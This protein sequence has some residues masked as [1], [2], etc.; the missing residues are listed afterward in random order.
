MKNGMINES[1][2][3]DLVNLLQTVKATKEAA[4][5]FVGSTSQLYMHPDG[6]IEVDTGAGAEHAAI[7]SEL[8]PRFETTKHA[9]RQMCA[10]AKI[11]A[12]Y[13]DRCPPELLAI[14]ANHWFK[15]GTDDKGAPARML[16]TMQ[17]SELLGIERPIVR[18]FTS[19]KYRRVDNW[20]FVNAVFPVLQEYHDKGLVIDSVN[21]G[22]HA[23]HLKG[24]IEGIEEVIMRPGAVMGQGHDTYYKVRPGFELKNGETGQSALQFAPA[25]YDDGCTNLAIFRENAQRRLHVGRSQADGELWNMLTDETQAQSNKALMMQLADYCRASLDSS[26]KVFQQTCDLLREKCG[27]E[28]KRPEATFKLVADQ[29]GL[30]EDETSGCVA[31]LLQRGDMSVFGIQAAITQFSQEDAVSY[32]RASELEVIGGDILAFNQWDHLLAKADELKIRVAA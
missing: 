8:V 30:S 17:P 15:N 1:G 7:E 32:D 2:Q 24:H 19:D 10:W 26:G 14:N 13:A 11:P 16:R 4:Q 18:A 27:I 12:Q 5:D 25:L 29:F 23:M 31:A 20:D 6:S 22:E 3:P 28:V 21:V 9:R